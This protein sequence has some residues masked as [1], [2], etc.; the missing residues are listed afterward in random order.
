MAMSPLTA[1]L[2]SALELCSL[3]EDARDYLMGRG[4]TPDVIEHWGIKV[5]DA[6]PEPFPDERLRKYYGPCFERFEGKI[7]YPLYGP[8]GQLLGIDTRS[9]DA[10]DDDRYLLPESRWNPVWI[11]MPQAMPLVY[12]GADVV[13]VEGRFDVFPMYHAT[14]KAVLGSGTAHLSWKQIEFLRRWVKG[15]VYM[16][17]DRDDGGRK[18]V[19]DALRDLGKRRVECSELRYGVNGDDPGTIWDRGGSAAM[20]DAFPYL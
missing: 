20:R 11:G 9:M 12:D 7:V 13:V 17:Y 14:D 6:P 16:C 1:W 10:K 5:F 19:E 4:A 2:V 3:T 15:H 8:R 18:G